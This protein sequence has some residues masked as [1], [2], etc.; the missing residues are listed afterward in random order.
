[1]KLFDALQTIISFSMNTTFQTTTISDFL[2]NFAGR[3]ESEGY[4]E[5]KPIKI[6]ECNRDF[7]WSLE[8]QK[9]FIRSILL[10]YPI[11]AM[12]I[13]NGDILDGGNRTTTIWL[14][15]NGVFSVSLTE[16]SLE[17]DY[18]TMC[19]DRALT[20]RWDSAVIPQQIITNATPDQVAQIYEN[21]NKGVRLTFGQLLENRRY[22]AWVRLAEAMVGRG[23]GVYDDLELLKR[24]WAP[25]F[26]KTKNRSELG[27]TFQVLVA[28]ELGPAYFNQ[29][30]SYHIKLIM[31]DT[32]PS[33]SNLRIMLSMIDLCDRELRV[34]SKKK[35]EVFKK[36]I[37]A[38]IHDFHAFGEAQRT[39]WTA[40]WV[41]FITDAYS[42]L[43]NKAISIIIDVGTLR[44]TN[45]GRI[46]GVAR[47]V[48]KYLDDELDIEEGG[49]SVQDSDSD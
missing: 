2:D 8:M 13:A 32:P 41:E 39:Q 28:A 48:Q 25:R 45:D 7:V 26:P 4:D 21:L 38:I 44:A 6:A 18:R 35:K 29:T 27:F 16:G 17:L 15:R 14:F 49:E 33:S 46:A 30:F 47:N 37:G 36:F 22:R 5:S 1:M 11:P 9:G 20:R 12:C 43:T 31:G 10:G 23:E 40:K 24:V 3:K 42:I 34:P 19:E